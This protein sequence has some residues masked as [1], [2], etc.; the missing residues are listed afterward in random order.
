MRIYPSNNGS[1]TMKKIVRIALPAAFALSAFAAQAYT[2]E[3][4][5][6]VVGGTMALTTSAPSELLAAPSTKA[7]P[8]LVQ[9][10]F[11]GP[12]V[13]PDYAKSARTLPVA[14]SRPAIAKPWGP[15][16]NA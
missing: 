10:N 15:G 4:D 8:F 3:T 6:P 9:S 1:N 7:A 12:K 16:H 2:L 11:E 5:Y 14:P 13:D